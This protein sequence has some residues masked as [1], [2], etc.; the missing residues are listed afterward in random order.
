MKRF[1]EVWLE[2]RQLWLKTLQE[3]LAREPGWQEALQAAWTLR[4]KNRHPEIP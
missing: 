2:E 4:K 1:D 3:L